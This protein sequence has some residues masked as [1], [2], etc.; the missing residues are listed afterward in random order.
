MLSS[1]IDEKLSRAMN[2]FLRHKCTLITYT[3]TGTTDDSG[4]EEYTEVTT[5]NIACLFLWRDVSNTDERGTVVERMPF[6][7]LK[8]SQ[9][10]REGDIVQNVLTHTS[11]N[12][13]K[14]AKINTIDTTAEMGDAIIKVCSLEGASL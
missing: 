3:P 7:Y 6:L 2:R 5:S 10:V 13:L 12:I 8:N 14:S 11:V 4:H 9:T 1:R